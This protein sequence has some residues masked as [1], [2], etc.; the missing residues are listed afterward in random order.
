[1]STAIGE[2]GSERVEARPEEVRHCCPW[3]GCTRIV[4]ARFWGCPDHWGELPEEFR[5]AWMRTHS[6]Y[7]AVQSV[8]NQSAVERIR[9]WVTENAQRVESRAT[10]TLSSEFA[11]GYT[12][13]GDLFLFWPRDREYILVSRKHVSLLQRMVLASA[14]GGG[15]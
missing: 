6:P 1:M 13:E 12:D 11:C 8:A 2:G 4:S 10:K 7:R 15:Q 3:P 14:Q 5:F 9:N